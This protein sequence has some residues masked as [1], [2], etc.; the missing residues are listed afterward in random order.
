[1][2]LTYEIIREIKQKEKS[3]RLQKLPE[4]FFKDAAGY[5][6]LKKGTLEESAARNLVQSIFEL[7]KKKILNIASLSYKVDRIPDNLEPEEKKL[8]LGVIKILR[9]YQE[10][11]EGKIIDPLKENNQSDKEV[12]EEKKQ[13]NQKPIK[14]QEYEKEE[15]SPPKTKVVFLVDIPEI[16]L[17]SGEKCCFKEGEKKEFEME[18]ARVLEEKGLCKII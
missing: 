15:K 3:E 8:Y 2:I 9:E 14:K 7:R 17:P 10:S 1:M 16:I 12:G 11:F 6:N 4:F 18:F 13:Q 5:I